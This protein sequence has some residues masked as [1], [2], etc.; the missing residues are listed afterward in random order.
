MTREESTIQSLMGHIEALE[1]TIKTLQQNQKWIPVTERLPEEYGEYLVSWMPTKR[2][3]RDE[4][5]GRCLI[6]FCFFDPDCTPGLW[7]VE[8]MPE[9]ACYGVEIFAWMPS[10]ESYELQE[11]SDKE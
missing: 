8:K 2:S 5:H 11:R 9:H 1:E 4:L 7:C 3:V 10:P 6:G